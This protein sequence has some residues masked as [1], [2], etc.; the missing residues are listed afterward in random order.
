MPSHLPE[1]PERK[2]CKSK[3]PMPIPDWAQLWHKLGNHHADLL[4]TEA[5]KT[6]AL[7]EDI[8]NP[9]IQRV[10]EL[11]LIQKRLA[12]IICY[13]PHR[14]KNH[15][16]PKIRRPIET[17]DEL[18]RMSNHS[19]SPD[20]AGFST[21]A[22]S[23][24]LQ[25]VACHGSCMTKS[26][27]IKAFLKGECAPC[28]LDPDFRVHG[29]IS[30]NNAVSHHTHKLILSGKTYVC[31]MCGYKATERLSKLKYACHPNLKSSYKGANLKAVEDGTF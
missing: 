21:L 16:S 23:G 7:H 1:D 18:L 26:R 24:K 30:I 10:S 22:K 19:F 28:V 8:A 6:F 12:S 3:D 20:W 27:G 4:A 11:Q 14:P 25:C 5:G 17:L 15:R 29:T 13:M 31:T 9:I 2:R